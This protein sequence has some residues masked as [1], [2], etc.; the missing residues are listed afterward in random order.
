MEHMKPSDRIL[1]Q[2][3][4]VKVSQSQQDRVSTMREKFQR[5]AFEIAGE[6]AESAEKTVMLRKLLESKDCAVRCLCESAFDKAYK[7]Q[8][9]PEVPSQ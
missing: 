2:F 8:P 1:R 7:P 5:F 3:T 6:L 9:Q 4:F